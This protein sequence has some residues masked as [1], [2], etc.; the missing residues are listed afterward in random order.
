MK[1]KLIKVHPDN[2]TGCERCEMV[3][4]FHHEQE[5]SVTKSRIKVLHD[6]D[7]F[8]WDWPLLCLQCVEAPCIES[9]TVGALYRD[10]STGI[11]VVDNVCTGC[12]EC[13]TACPLHALALDEEKAVIFKCDLCGGDPECVKWCARGVL[14]LEE[15]DLDSPDR[16]VFVDEATKRL[17]IAG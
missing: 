11:V 7:R 3:C 9:C 5:S 10:E 16:K 17:Q 15:V 4:S 1:V 6:P 2:C 8:D 13:I 12:G 14:C